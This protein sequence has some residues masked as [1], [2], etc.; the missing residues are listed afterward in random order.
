VCLLLSHTFFLVNYIDRV[1]TN[2]FLHIAEVINSDRHSGAVFTILN[3]LTNVSIKPGWK[4]WPG[5]NSLVDWP[6]RK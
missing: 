2:S 4:G 5:T 3:F 1:G 6:Q